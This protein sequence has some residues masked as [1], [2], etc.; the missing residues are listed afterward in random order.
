MP[1]YPLKNRCL[2]NQN[3]GIAQTHNSMK[4]FIL[5]IILLCSQHCF[6][7]GT[8]SCCVNN[9]T[10]FAKCTGNKY[11]KACSNCSSCKY[12]VGGRTCGVCEKGK[13]QT[14][15]S[16]KPVATGQCNAITKKGTRCSRKAGSNGYCWQHGG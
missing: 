15:K 10:T 14:Y 1:H 3:T 4:P 8:D 12:C 11:C 9:S 6:A 16:S 2:S 7:T 5:C 13:K